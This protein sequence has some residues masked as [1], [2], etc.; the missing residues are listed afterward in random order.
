MLAANIIT[1]YKQPK[2]VETL[3]RTMQHA[4]FH[5]YLHIDR[6]ADMRQFE[7]LAELPNVFF[8]NKRLDIKW[9]GYSMVEA[10]VCGMRQA[11]NSGH[12]YDCITHLS[13]QCLPLKPVQELCNYYK[14]NKGKI[15]LSC[16]PAPNAWWDQARRRTE[17]YHFHQFNFRGKY[18]LGNVVSRLLPK[19]KS[20][21]LELYGGPQ[22]AYWTITPG[23]AQYVCDVLQTNRKVIRFFQ[24]VWGPDEIVVNSLIMNSPFRSQVIN[25]NDRYIDWSG[26]GGHPK[27]LTTEDFDRIINSRCLFARKFDMDTD[28]NVVELLENYLCA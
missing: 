27:T 16:S 17:N 11:L 3:L 2:L 19:R 20:P 22:G 24:Y 8:V 4:C 18:R 10:L 14:A 13:G 6:K 26:G 15:L 23:A 5:F 28:P 21:G 25:R 7:Y 12:S 9:A 1:V